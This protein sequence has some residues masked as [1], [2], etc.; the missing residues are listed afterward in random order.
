MQDLKKIY[1]SFEVADVDA[2]GLPIKQQ[3]PPTPPMPPPPMK[4][5]PKYSNPNLDKIGY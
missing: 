3:E 2:E 1:N 5:K 4:Q